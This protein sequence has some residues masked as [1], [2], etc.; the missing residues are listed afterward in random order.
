MQTRAGGLGATW[1]GERG[2]FGLAASTYRSE[3][4]IPAGAHVHAGDDHGHGHD[5]HDHDEHGHEDEG[6]GH[7][8]DVRIDMVQNR[9]E[10]KGGIYD[11]LSFLERIDLHGAW[12]D[13]EHVELEGLQSRARALADELVA[14]ETRASDTSREVAKAEADVEQ[15]RQRAARDRARLEA[16][17]G[18]HK[19]LES[20]QHELATLA[21]RQ[22]DLEDVELEVMER[23]ETV[24]DTVDRLTTERDQLQEQVDALVARRDAALETLAAEAPALVERLGDATAGAIEA[25]ANV[26]YGWRARSG[27]TGLFRLG[28]QAAV[29]PSLAGEGMGIA[30]ASGMIAARAWQD[31]G[32]MAAASWQARFARRASTPLAIAG[33]VRALA[34]HPVLAA[35]LLAPLARAGML[36]RLARWTRIGGE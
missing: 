15:V 12:S 1:L 21:R 19:E 7:E 18:G 26:P 20:L 5:E 29:I 27:E 28:D 4:G 17:Q 36:E 22:S 13:Y 34:E 32:G 16:G 9:L 11:P 6:H 3:Y 14:A 31:G 10:L 35:P 2:Y 25:V 33:A 24:N 23:L 30:L 8:E